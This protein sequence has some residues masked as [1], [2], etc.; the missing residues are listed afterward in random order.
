MR[1]PR[2]FVETSL[3]VD[4][5]IPLPDTACEHLLRVLRLPAGA[6]L[7]VCNGDGIDYHARLGTAG[8]RSAT[9]TIFAQSA[10]AT[11][12]PLPIVL[13]QALA[14]GEKMDW[15]VQKATELGV[16]AIA[17]VITE[18]TEVRL[19]D[20][21]AQRRLA[22]WRAIAIAACEQCGRADL[23]RIS[24]PV[25]LGDHLAGIDTDTLRLTLDPEGQSLTRVL[26]MAPAKPD[27]IRIHLVVG[28]EGGLSGRD[29]AQLQAGRFQGARLGP[30]ILRT[31][32]AGLA[33]IA[34]MQTLAGDF[35]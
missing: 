33:A 25:R 13:V 29:L 14:R 9:A 27:P 3:A 2:C 23:P 21:R 17:P 6:E 15:I 11:R 16:T 8:R 5:E 30:R 20:D 19:D 28:P 31:E 4:T 34:A 10:N 22:H 26:A 32:T 24:A 7:I 18:R 35:R 1:I 12:S